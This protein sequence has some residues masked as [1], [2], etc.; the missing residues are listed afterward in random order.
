MEGLIQLV[1]VDIRPQDLPEF[2]WHHL[3]RDMELLGKATG[4]SV[5]DSAIIVHLVLRE[6]LL[7][8][9]L[10]C[11]DINC[12]DTLAVDAIYIFL[13]LYSH[14]LTAT[15]KTVNHLENRKT[16]EEWEGIFNQ[17]YIQPILQVAIITLVKGDSL[18][19]NSRLGR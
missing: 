12:R 17:N 1:K 2:F 6:I 9:P 8:D 5:D 13:Y 4:K 14:P 16:R 19:W 7:R 10:T 11:E 18:A 15:V 3:E